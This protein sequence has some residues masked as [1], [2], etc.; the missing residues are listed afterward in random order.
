MR[1]VVLLAIL[2]GCAE[3]HC[4]PGLTPLFVDVSPAARPKP[5]GLIIIYQCFE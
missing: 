2:S 1:W 3:I 4:R 5:D